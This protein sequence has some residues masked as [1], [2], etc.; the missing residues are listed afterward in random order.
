MVQLEFQFCL[1]RFHF[2]R[3]N[4]ETLVFVI[5][6]W[7]RSVCLLLWYKSV[8]FLCQNGREG[9]HQLVGYGGHVTYIIATN[10]YKWRN[11]DFPS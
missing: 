11:L 5:S 7:L 4:L 3:R 8:C 10:G 2:D 6:Q 9:P 1:D